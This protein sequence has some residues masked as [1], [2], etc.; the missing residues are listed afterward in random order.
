MQPK[1]PAKG[2]GR[3]QQLAPFSKA[4]WRYNVYFVVKGKPTGQVRLFFCLKTRKPTRKEPQ[5]GGR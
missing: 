4:E 5:Y 1:A 2:V 3:L